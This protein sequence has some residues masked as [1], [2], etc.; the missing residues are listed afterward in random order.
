VRNSW[1]SIRIPSISLLANA[2]KIAELKA[3]PEPEL[4]AIHRWEIAQ[5]IL[6]ALSASPNASTLTA[7]ANRVWTAPDITALGVGAVIN[8]GNRR[9]GG[10]VCNQRVVVCGTAG[11]QVD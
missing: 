10:I 1:A 9:R 3:A 5:V 8:F 11:C 6:A 2:A 4:V 7:A